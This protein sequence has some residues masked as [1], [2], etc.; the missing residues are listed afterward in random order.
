[1]NAVHP[2]YVDTDMTSHKGP[3]TIDEGA[4]APLFLALDAPDSVKGEYVWYNKQIVSWDG[5]RAVENY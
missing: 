2:G 1:M 3:L 4:I 5:E